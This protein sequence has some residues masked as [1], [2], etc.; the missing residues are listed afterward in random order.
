MSISLK[1]QRRKKRRRSY[2]DWKPP[3]NRGPRNDPFRII[4]YLVA[5][6]AGIWVILNQDV[7]KAELFGEDAAGQVAAGEDGRAA[8]S[9]RRSATDTEGGASETTDSTD[10]EMQAEAAFQ[11]GQLEQA[12]EYYRQAAEANP[13]NVNNYVQVA[14]LLIYQ[15]AVSPSYQSE[16]LLAQALEAAETAILVDPFDPAGYAIKGKV[17]D[18]QG[19]PDQASSTILRAL[20]IDKDYALAHSYLGEAYVD[21]NRWDQAEEELSQA[22]ALDPN[23]VDIRRDYG[24]MYEMFGDY[25]AASIQYEAALQ[26]HPR[27]IP[28]RVALARILREQGSYEEAL[29]QLFEAQSVDPSNALVAYEMGRTYETYIGDTDSALEYYSRATELAENFGSPW[30]RMASLRYFQGRYAD[31]IIAFERA[32]ALD[33]LPDT[34]LYQVGLAYA[35]DDRCDTAI[36]YLDEALAAAAGDEL[37]TDAVNSGYELCS[38]PTPTPNPN[39]TPTDEAD[40]GADA[41]DTAS[42]DGG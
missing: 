18:W 41:D 5:I 27:L 16:E 38:A 7:V 3:G 23:Q 20:D 25:A 28:V 21:L 12:V 37:I 29:D 36:Q 6:A 10:L 34:L 31:S 33:A 26:Q 35:N 15:A 11:D 30:V 2:A 22:V 39:A 42:G 24:Y 17:Y 14:R 40:T 8:L 13:E 9:T 32:I 1:E 19:R 4:F